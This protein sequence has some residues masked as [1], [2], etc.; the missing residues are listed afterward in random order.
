MSHDFEDVYLPPSLARIAFTSSPR[1]STTMTAVASGGEQRNK[2]WKHPLRRFVAPSAITCDEQVEDI[3]DHWLV[4]G[5]PFI[6][7]PLRDPLDFASVRLLK[8]NLAPTLSPTDQ[9]FGTG[10][11]LTTEFQLKKTYMRG[12][13]TYVRNITL[14]IVDSVLVAMNGLPPGTADPALPGGPYDWEA[15]RT[16]GIVTFDPAPRAGIVLTAGFLFDV[17]VRF[18]ADDVFDQIVSS[19]QVRQQADLS[20]VEMRFPCRNGDSG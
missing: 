17:A 10:D 1:T 15:D 11:G 8:A 2:N 6:G 4:M 7:F 16:T 9:Q 5:G 20:F 18:E 14:V 3:K 19:Y 12:T 13:R